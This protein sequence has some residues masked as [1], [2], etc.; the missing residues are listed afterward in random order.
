MTV[1]TSERLGERYTSERLPNGLTLLLCPM[2]A[3][4]NA[5][6][7]IAANFGSIDRSFSVDGGPM[8]TLPDGVAHFLEHKLFENADGDAFDKY[9]KTGANA[10]A[11]TS[12]TNTNYL[13]TSTGHFAENLRILLGF[14]SAPWFTAESVAKEQGIIGQEIE[15]YA[16]DPDWQGFSMLMSALYSVVPL[17]ADIAGSRESIAKITPELLYDCYRAFYDPHKLT[18]VVSG[19]F[20]PDEVR[21][22]CGEFFAGREPADVR[23][24]VLSEPREI[25]RSRV[26]RRMPVALPQFSIGFKER[27]LGEREQAFRPI[28]LELLLDMLTSDVSA[29]YRRLYDGGIINDAFSNDVMTFREH[30]TV[31]FSGESREPERVFDALCTEFERARREGLDRRA[32]ER[33]RRAVYARQIRRLSTPESAASFI[34]DSYFAKS[35]VYDIIEQTAAAKFQ[36]VE[37]LL[38]ETL[39]GRYA[40]MGVILPQDEAEGEH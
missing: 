29:F 26:E 21:S 40:A 2:P 10:N 17:G 31:M 27:P 9:A 33:S 32:F 22:I 1:F 13:F 37:A 39:D 34:L 5:Y 28:L 36:D 7:G 20:D 38:S 24:P 19:R 35:N 15:M 14:V 30:C 12:F 6:A 25:V 23:F 18:L 16:D 11:F 4:R 3:F 8:L